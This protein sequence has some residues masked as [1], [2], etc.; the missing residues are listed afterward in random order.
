MRTSHLLLHN[1]MSQGNDNASQ[2]D[3]EWKFQDL[4]V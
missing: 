1:I 4:S 2:N 3:S